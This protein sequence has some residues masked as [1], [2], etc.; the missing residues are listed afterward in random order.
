[1]DDFYLLALS[2]TPGMGPSLMRKIVKQAKSLESFSAKCPGLLDK[3]D[4]S[5]ETKESLMQLA[6]GEPGFIGRAKKAHDYIK[7]NNIWM[8]NTFEG[9]FPSRLTQIATP[10]SL[11][12]IRGRL[13]LLD[14]QQ[15]AIVGTR[16][17][18]LYGK[19]ITR[20][21]GFGLVE[22][23]FSICSG[24][25][26]GIDS[27]AHK[28][29]LDA[30]GNT[31]AVMANGIDQVYPRRN[32]YLAEAIVDN[33]GALVTEFAPGFKPVKNF[34][35]RRNRLISGL[36]SGVLV[37]EA[38]EKSGSLITAAYALEQNREVFAIPGPVSNTMSQGCH[39]LIRQG[40]T[41]VT[42]IADI[43]EEL[44]SAGVPVKQVSFPEIEQ[45]QV[46]GVLERK[47]MECLA[48]NAST[49]DALAD[50]LQEPMNQLQVA[51]V[52]LELKGFVERAAGGIIPSGRFP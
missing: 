17:P 7:Q 49:F 36:S 39:H 6:G 31:I 26:L 41:L 8:I 10:P 28:A 1:M 48:G 9:F 42:G 46:L 51:V 14:D 25:A 33:G 34:F 27:Q 20:H 37:V 16:K 35:V 21:F 13:E 15:L 32:K 24:L 11:L 44:P 5:P 23:G 40:A 2:M 22:Q 18:T 47:V 3:L 45:A 12:F 19:E 43:L 38:A 29:A 4:V 50:H 30:G 52:Q